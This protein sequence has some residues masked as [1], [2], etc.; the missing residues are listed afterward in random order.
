MS[1]SPPNLEVGQT[2]GDY[3]IVAFLGRGGM[4]SVF[5]VRNVVSDRIEAMKVLLPDIDNNPEAARRFSQ[6][7]KLVATLDHPNI[8]AL[9]TALRSGTHL[10][11][12]MEYIE[13][14]SLEEK[15][16]AE[17]ISVSRAVRYMCEVLSGLSYAH[18]HGVVHRDVKPS[19]IMIRSNDSL[20]L[21]DFGIATRV[22]DPR[23]T[24]PGAAPGSIYY[25]SPE[26]VKALPIDARSDLYSAGVTLYE[27]VTGQR[28]IQGESYFA[29]LRAHLDQRPVPAFELAPE[30]PRP[31]SAL[32]EK[33]L[34]KSPDGRFQTADEFRAALLALASGTKPSVKPT[35]TETPRPVE[36]ARAVTGHPRDIITAS[37]ASSSLDAAQLEAVR[38][39]L[40]VYVGPLAKILV[41]RAAKTARSLRDLYQLLAAEIPSETDRQEFLRSQPF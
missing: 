25:M 39:N 4:G 40:A 16:R 27:M 21:T 34:E 17:K 10:M 36:A 12:V 14:Q 26:Q 7:I 13:G 38:K 11:M 2:I 23:L 3:Q 1:S 31:L 20:K 18:Q 5:K 6:E 35:A 30:V 41:P 29:I 22:G 32:I 19:N 9:R 33:A 24:A 28:P 8:A 15:L 37:A